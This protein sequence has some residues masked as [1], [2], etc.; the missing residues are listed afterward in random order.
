VIEGADHFFF[1]SLDAL[2][3]AVGDWVAAVAA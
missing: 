3:E 2:A 1:G